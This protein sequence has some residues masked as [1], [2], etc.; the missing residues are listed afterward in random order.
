MRYERR[1]EQYCFTYYDRVLGRTRRLLKCEHPV[2]KTEQE[3]KEFVKRWDAEKDAYQS[4]LLRSMAWR[5]KFHDF[6]DLLRLYEKGV[7]EEAPLSWQQYSSCIRHYVFPFFLNQKGER[8]INNWRHHFE[9]F[10]EHLLETGSFKKTSTGEGRTLS[11]SSINVIVKALNSFMK[12]IRRRKGLEQFETCR[13]FR[14]GLMPKRSVESVLTLEEQTLLYEGLSSRFPQAATFFSL[15]LHTG[16]RLG[17]LMGISLAD[18]YA[19]PPKSEELEHSLRPHGLIPLGY[20]LLDSQISD[21]TVVRGE[22][23]SVE[24][25]PLKGKKSMDPSSARIIPLFDREAYNHVVQ[26]WNVQLKLYHQKRYGPEAKSYLLFDQLTKSIFSRALRSIQE[27][28]KLR[29][30]FSVHDC[31]HTYSTWLAAKTDGNYHLCR[32]ILGH[33]KVEMTMRYVHVNAQMQ[34]QLQTDFQ[35]RAPLRVLA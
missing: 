2:I 27:V 5:K 23:G 10:R 35:L 26:L 29:R 17:E 28:V 15:A 31:R 9:E 8:N 24:R 14:A 11:Y 3:A 33:S 12:I 22:D 7:R 1:G 19:E 20:F 30:I 25:K 21:Q 6:D 4:R 16:M 32:T 13:L 18:F 34:R